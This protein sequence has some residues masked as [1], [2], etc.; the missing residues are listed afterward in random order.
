MADRNAKQGLAGSG[1]GL[2]WHPLTDRP[3]QAPGSSFL[4]LGNIR[5]RPRETDVESPQETQTN[6]FHT[7]RSTAVALL[8]D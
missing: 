3:S 6:Q 2:L 7:S 8:T 4:R 1:W 5:P